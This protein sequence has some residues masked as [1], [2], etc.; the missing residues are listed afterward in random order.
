M[1]HD[2]YLLTQDVVSIFPDSKGKPKV[3]GKKGEKVKEVSDCDTVLIVE[4]TK[5][6]RF[7]AHKTKLQKL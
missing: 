4:D 5:G 1:M 6:E 3:Y 2:Q 7:P